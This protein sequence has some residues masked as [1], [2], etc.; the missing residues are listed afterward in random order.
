[1]DPAS[2]DIKIIL[3]DPLGGGEIGGQIFDF[4]PKFLQKGD[5]I[6]PIFTTVGKLSLSSTNTVTG[7]FSSPRN[8]KMPSFRKVCPLP[9]KLNMRI[10]RKTP[11]IGQFGGPWLKNATCWPRYFSTD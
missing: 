4:N 5:S 9:S 3:L 8:K 2:R 11:I 6:P 1:M 10:Y 7:D